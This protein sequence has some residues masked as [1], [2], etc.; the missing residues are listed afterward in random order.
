MPSPGDISR[1]AFWRHATASP[2]SN[3]HAF[4]FHPAPPPRPQPYPL[5]PDWGKNGTNGAPVSSPVHEA[6]DPALHA[7]EAAADAGVQGRALQPGPRRHQEAPGNRAAGRT[8]GYR[9]RK[10]LRVTMVCRLEW[11]WWRG[12][13]G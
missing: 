3:L 5:H 6:P 12:W 2:V 13:W 1:D 11:T 10:S 9:L 8:P 7:Q 4:R